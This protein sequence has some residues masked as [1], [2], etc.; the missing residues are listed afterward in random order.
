MQ[1]SE[2]TVFYHLE[3]LKTYFGEKR[4]GEITQRDIEEW[5]AD[6]STKAEPS[7]VNRQL[8]TLKSLFRK[9]VQWNKLPSNPSKSIAK[10]RENSGRT[11][12][13]TEQEIRR[14]YEVASL[15][16]QQ[17]LTLAL[18]SGMRKS[19]L[20]NLQW[21]DI[22]FRNG[23]IHVIK[24]KSGKTYD[25]PINNALIGLFKQLSKD[26]KPGRVL[27]STNLR[28]EFIAT[29]QKADITD[30][31]LHDL[32]HT[33]AS[34]LAMK[35]ID[36]YTISQ[37]LG[38]SDIKMTQRYAHLTPNHKKIAVNMINFADDAKNKQK[39]EMKVDYSAN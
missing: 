2:K 31:T 21:E 29:L 19:N 9:A 14:L 34:H 26:K 22:D 6:F 10:L 27:D 16:L 5:K 7:T 1:K 28:S 18:N 35:G 11:R 32:R 36:L 3:K 20:V 24:T 39:Q 25:V 38:H 17:F 37:L 33:F 8:T 13:L 4:L 30:C 12:Y 15:K 23:V